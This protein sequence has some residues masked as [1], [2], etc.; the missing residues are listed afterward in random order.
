MDVTHFRAMRD[1]LSK[2]AEVS[3][4][5]LSPQT[6]LAQKP[7]PPMETPGMQKALAVID[8]M[9][10]NKTAAR[11]RQSA[12]PT[13]SNAPYLPQG[14]ASE[15]SKLDRAKS[16]GAHTLGGMGAGRLISDFTPHG[17]PQ[18]RKFTAMAI[19]GAVGVADYLH[20]RHQQK[21][22]VAKTA[23]VASP[24]LHLM[25]SQKVGKLTQTLKKGPSLKSQVPLIG[26]KGSL[27]TPGE[28]P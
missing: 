27:P 16:L 13:L 19:G 7:A 22:Q 6:V 4:H 8:R 12:A 23:A 26:R 17:A 11:K 5:G 3:L 15:G 2:I 24:G 20:K 28:L 21:K 10:M 14:Q 25:A 1:E 18:S 9:Q